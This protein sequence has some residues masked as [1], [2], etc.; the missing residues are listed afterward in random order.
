MRRRNRPAPILPVDKALNGRLKKD[1]P[2]DSPANVLVYFDGAAEPTNPG[3]GGYGMVALHRDTLVILAEGWRYLG[4]G[5][6]NNVAEW[7][8]CLAALAWITEHY[9]LHKGCVYELR[10]DSMLVL[11]QL[12]GYYGCHKPHLAG[13]TSEGRRMLQNLP[14][15]MVRWVPRERNTLA[16]ERSKLA[17]ANYITPV[18]DPDLMFA[19]AAGD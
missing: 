11:K 14:S 8:G 9:I 4:N 12:T 7:E 1:S 13:L 5:I 19:H 6:T 16:D 18:D 10:G 3:H 15:L 2:D 17:V